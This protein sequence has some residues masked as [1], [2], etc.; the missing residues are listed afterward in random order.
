MGDPETD[1]GT[2]YPWILTTQAAKSIYL[3]PDYNTLFTYPYALGNPADPYE[4]YDLDQVVFSQGYWGNFWN[5]PNTSWYA[6]DINGGYLISNEPIDLSQMAYLN[7]SILKLPGGGGSGYAYVDWSA[8]ADTT[9]PWTVLVD[10]H[11]ISHSTLDWVPYSIELPAV[12][13]NGSQ[14]Y[15]RVRFRG[16]VTTGWK[17]APFY[18]QPNYWM[19]DFR[20]D[21]EEILPI[22]LSS[23]TAVLSNQNFVNLTWVTQTETGVSGFYIYRGASDDL[24]TAEIISPMISAT[25]TSQPQTYI[26]TDTALYDSGTYYYWLQNV[27]FDGTESFHGPVAV[28]YSNT[29][30][31]PAPPVPNLTE[32]QAIYPNP[33]NPTAYIPFSLANEE[34]VSFHIYNPRGQLVRHI[35]AGFKDS[36]QHRIAWDGRDQSGNVLTNGVY[37]IRMTAG[38]DSYQRKALLLK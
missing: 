3:P 32:L 4:Y 25:N 15:L 34:Y 16:N 37:Y 10:A 23:F 24:A 1:Q 33:F 21:E 38:K 31:N 7:L 27:D 6:G 18:P 26:F 13:E 11:Q 29:Q 19:D 2:T 17:D 5:S 9:G 22:E 36:G 28:T 20:V 35:D 8:T 12:T 30:D 14:V